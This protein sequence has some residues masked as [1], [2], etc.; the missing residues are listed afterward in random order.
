[1]IFTSLSELSKE[2]SQQI[3]MIKLFLPH[4]RTLEN[5]SGIVKCPFC[6]VHYLC[7]SPARLFRLPTLRLT[8]IESYN[9]LV[10]IGF[11]ILFSDIN[12]DFLVALRSS[13]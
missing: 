12:Q 6:H 5:T 7:S 3:F 11:L 2:T 13:S 10:A 4:T 1:M 9:I 8:H